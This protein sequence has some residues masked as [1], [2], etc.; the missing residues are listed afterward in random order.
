MIEV[1]C[2]LSVKK[3]GGDGT[4]NESVRANAPLARC[5]I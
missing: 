1:G 2:L 5:G 4:R 3:G